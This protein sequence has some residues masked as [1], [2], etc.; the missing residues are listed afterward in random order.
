[1]FSP[2]RLLPLPVPGGGERGECDQHPSEEL[3]Q[4]CVIPHGDLL[5]KSTRIG[6]ERVCGLRRIREGTSQS[7][8]P[9]R[10]RLCWGVSRG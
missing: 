3:L 7:E 2:Q 10:R 5:L 6:H 9:F 1:M 8:S 4:L